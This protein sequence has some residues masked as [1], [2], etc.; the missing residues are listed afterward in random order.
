M[1]QEARVTSKGQITIPREIR[2]ALRI[3]QGDTIVFE[4]DED[5]VYLHVQRPASVFAKYEGIWREG[6][7]LTREEID[8]E[9]REMRGHEP[10]EF[11]EPGN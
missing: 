9:I 4:T 7:G 5:R 2:R 3:E 1:H 11:R 8:A 10:D 6:K